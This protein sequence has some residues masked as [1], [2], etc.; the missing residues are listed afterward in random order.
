MLNELTV[1]TKSIQEF[2]TLELD[3]GFQPRT[4]PAF[5]KRADKCVDADGDC[6]DLHAPSGTLHEQS[7][8]LCFGNSEHN[9]TRLVA[10]S[11]SY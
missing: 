10:R 9:Q 2:G 7:D 4:P 5:S 8:N 3:F 1:I 6:N 11:H